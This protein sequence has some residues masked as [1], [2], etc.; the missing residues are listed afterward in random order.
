MTDAKTPM[1][2]IWHAAVTVAIGFLTVDALPGGLATQNKTLL[3]AA[4]F[5]AFLTCLAQTAIYTARD[6]AKI[7]EDLTT[8]EGQ[9]R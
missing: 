1:T 9:S 2:I 6:L 4:V 3:V 8:A 7:R 5:T